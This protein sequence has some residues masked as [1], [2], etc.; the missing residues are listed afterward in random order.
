M[1]V[2]DDPDRKR[3]WA[4]ERTKVVRET[5]FCEM[6]NMVIGKFSAQAAEDQGP[7]SLSKCVSAKLPIHY[8]TGRG[9]PGPSA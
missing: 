4:S 6:R 9:G 1:K 3:K 8:E 7:F 2:G 5:V